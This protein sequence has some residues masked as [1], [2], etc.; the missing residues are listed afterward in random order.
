M[1]WARWDGTP[2][3]VFGKYFFLLVLGLLILMFAYMVFGGRRERIQSQ[4]PGGGRQG[5]AAAGDEDGGGC[6]SH[7]PIFSTI[8]LI[9]EVA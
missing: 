1:H 3:E 4:A 2:R 6:A 9:D 8:M 5:R 7:G